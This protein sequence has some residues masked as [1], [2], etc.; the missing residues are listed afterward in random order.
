MKTVKILDK[1]FEL[2][3]PSKEI[4]L[5]IEILADQINE[6]LKDKAV[7]FIVIL[8]GAFMFASDL[9]KRIS[10]D[11]RISFLKLASYAG[12]SSSGN[13]KQ[14]IGLNESLKD[15]TVGGN[16]TDRGQ[17]LKG[18]FDIWHGFSE[19]IQKHHIT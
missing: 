2:S 4:Q 3:I 18:L 8:N 7:V 15:K 11:S 12:A 10:L 1:K 19:R 6:E 16:L 14:L 5:K 17:G 9:Y 13:V